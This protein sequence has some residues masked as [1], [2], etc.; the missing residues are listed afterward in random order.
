[1]NL[2]AFIA[3]YPG[4]ILGFATL[5]I[6]L[7]IILFFAVAGLFTHIEIKTTETK[8]GPMV[9]A[10][11]TCVG[12]YKNAGDLFTESWSLLPHRGQI[13]LYY[14]DPQNVPENEQRSAVGPILSKGDEKPVKE[15][16]DIMVKHGYK[17]FYLPDPGFVVTTTFPFRTTFSF[18]IAIWRVYPKL[19][20]YISEK[21]LCAYP[22][23]E[24]YQSEDIIFMMPLSHQEEFFVTE[25]QEEQESVATTD[26][27][28]VL[29][30]DKDDDD[31]FLKPKTPVRV[32]RTSR[33]SVESSLTEAVNSLNNVQANNDS[34]SVLSS[35]I[36]EV[37][38]DNSVSALSS[39]YN[40][41]PPEDIFS[42]EPSDVEDV[43]DVSAGSTNESS[44]FDDLAE[45]TDIKQ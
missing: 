19:K 33:R 36:A 30:N 37:N 31:L 15:E 10:Y 38:G 13:G 3:E 1:M 16:M 28:S 6:L 35:V 21:S 29:T 20:K 32:S 22:A 14:D 34:R 5:L 2:T 12:P 43:D 7:T 17:I 23:I 24:V 11:K 45:D 42:E 25:F 44:S 40:Q 4:W 9:M 26:M 8:L 39:P 41:P 27:G 18:M